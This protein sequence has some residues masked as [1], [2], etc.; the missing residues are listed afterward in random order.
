M[1]AAHRP[2]YTCST[3]AAVVP[4]AT[5]GWCGGVFF[6]AF[7]TGVDSSG[8]PTRRKPRAHGA[9]R[10]AQAKCPSPAIQRRHRRP[11]GCPPKTDGTDGRQA[12]QAPRSGH[13]RTSGVVGWLFSQS[14]DLAT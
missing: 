13:V 4:L 2:Q 12:V 6:S 5:H 10:P 3:A 11:Q 14:D 7:K 8:R 9:K 1:A